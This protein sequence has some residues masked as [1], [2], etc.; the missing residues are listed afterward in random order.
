MTEATTTTKTQLMRHCIATIAYRATSV[1][2]DVPNGYA[3]FEVGAEVRTPR[4][5][6]GHMTEVLRFT[7]DKLH[8]P[9]KAADTG[10]W[11]SLVTGFFDLLDQ[12]D[13]ALQIPMKTVKFS[14][15]QLFQ[16]PLCDLL[17]H[18]GQLALI[19]RLAGSPVPG[20]NFY[21]ANISI[22]KEK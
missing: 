6:L 15:D 12:L 11:K 14:G 5:I 21:E 19:R 3:D 20:E 18:I 9:A 8:F 7:L 4:E 10:E 22:G 17:T 2:S 13:R 16:G 1:L